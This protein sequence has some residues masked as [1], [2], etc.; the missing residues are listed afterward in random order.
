M[1]VAMQVADGEHSLR[2]AGVEASSAAAELLTTRQV[3]GGLAR[4]PGVA[5]RLA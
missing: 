3:G 1:R 4:S 2:L 5:G